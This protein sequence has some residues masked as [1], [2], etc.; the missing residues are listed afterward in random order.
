MASTGVAIGVGS[1]TGLV[2]WSKVARGAP[3]HFAC[4]ARFHGIGACRGGAISVA[5]LTVICGWAHVHG[6][7]VGALG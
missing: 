3:R 1:S 6:E 4:V 7:A 5:I 2:V